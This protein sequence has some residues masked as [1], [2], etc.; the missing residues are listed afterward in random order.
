MVDDEYDAASVAGRALEKRG[1]HVRI[2]HNGKAALEVLPGFR[3]D[4]VFLD[5]GLPGLD[6]LDVARAFAPSPNWK[7]LTLIAA[8]GRGWSEDRQRSLQAGFDHHLVKPL[9]LEDIEAVLAAGPDRRRTASRSRFVT[10]Q[11]TSEAAG[12]APSRPSGSPV[13]AAELSDARCGRP[14]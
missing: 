9:A 12:S 1:H 3:P 2:V 7:H 11:L 14:D 5:I 6:G 4:A 10:E 8:T 13:C